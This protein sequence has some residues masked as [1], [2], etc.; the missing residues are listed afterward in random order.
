MLGY[1]NRPD[2]AVQ[3]FVEREGKRWLRTGDIATIDEDGYVRIVDRSKDMIAVGGFKVFP[4]QVEE[5]LLGH[6]VVREAMV[7]GVLDAYHGE[8]HRAFVVRQS[9]QAGE[10]E[11]I[12]R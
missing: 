1:W 11:A 2:A 9:G 4:S 5:V 7:L 10:A 6:P 12:A 3:I 8:M